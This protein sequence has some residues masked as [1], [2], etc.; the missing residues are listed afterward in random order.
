MSL[1]PPNDEKLPIQAERALKCAEL[2]EAFLE[3]AS[4]LRTPVDHPA[5]QLRLVHREGMQ[6]QK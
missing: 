5:P 6:V 1:S 2:F 4:L 3:S